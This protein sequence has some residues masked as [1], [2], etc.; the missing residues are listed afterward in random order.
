MAIF[1]I[2]FFLT[3]FCVIALSEV[4]KR[5]HPAVAGILMGLPLNA[6]ISSYFFHYEQGFDFLM[7]TIPWGIAGL[8]STMVF[9]LAYLWAGRLCRALPRGVQ[10][11]VAALAALLSWGAFGLVLQQIP[12]NLPVAVCVFIL[13]TAGNLKALKRFPYQ[14]DKTS[15][16]ASSVRI[17]LFRAAVAGASISLVT[18]F[19]N[20][21]GVAWSGIAGTF[22]AFMFPLMIVL[23]FEDGGKA[24]PGVIHA[25]SYSVTNLLLFYL[26]MYVLLP[27]LGIHIAYIILYVASALYLWRLGRFRARLARN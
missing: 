26:G 27:P 17:M 6:A 22:P 21:I 13:A 4:A 5:I 10:I 3:I 18:G 7:K 15:N 8:S 16:A 14:G 2:K 20:I 19:A 9:A 25:Y 23:H 12:M 11:C 1:F 24:Y